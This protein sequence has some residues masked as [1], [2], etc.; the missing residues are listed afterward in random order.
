M[1]VT[2]GNFPPVEPAA[3]MKQP[4]RERTKVLARHWVDYGFGAPKITGL[5]YIL[6]LLFLYALGGVLIATLAS[7]LDPLHPADWWNEPIVYQKLVLWTVL[8]E[9]FGVAGSWGPLAGHFKPMTAGFRHYARPGTLRLPPWPDRVPFTKGD[10]RT[11]VDAGLYFLLL[12]TLVVTL[13]LPGGHDALETAA[14][15]P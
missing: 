14:I 13:G 12:T 10:E 4:Y 5:I 3:F 2:T 15:G 7:G 8:L 9:C 6:K 1:G 11:E